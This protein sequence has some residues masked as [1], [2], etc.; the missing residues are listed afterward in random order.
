MIAVWYDAPTLSDMR[1]L[2]KAADSLRREYPGGTA[3]LNVI[4]SGTPMFEQSVRLEAQRLTREGHFSLAVAHLVLVGGLAGAAVRAFLGTVTLVGRPKDPTR[5]FGAAGDAL[6]WL[7]DHAARGPEA[8][9]RAEL[10]GA[11]S[12]ALAS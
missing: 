2:L 6:A 4:K 5:V 3:L 1:A 11:L 10:D 12:A 7:A 8:W 9:S